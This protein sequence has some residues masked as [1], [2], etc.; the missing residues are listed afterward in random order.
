MRMKKIELL[1]A[2]LGERVVFYDARF[3]SPITQNLS[4][5]LRRLSVGA[6]QVP[7][8]APLVRGRLLFFVED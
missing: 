3:P 2:R 5:L 6:V 7:P 8:R 4:Q 1:Y